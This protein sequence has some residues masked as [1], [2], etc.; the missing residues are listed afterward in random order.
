MSQI[1]DQDTVPPHPVLSAYYDRSGARSGF[2][3]SLFNRTAADYDAINGLLSLGTGAQYRSHVLRRT[4]IRPGHHLL[5]VATGTGLL[6]RAAMRLVGPE[7]RVV[8]L[9]LSERM[10]DMA[11]SRPGLLVVQGRAE[12]LP[13]PAAHFD[14]LTMGY[15]L[16][17]VASLTTAFQ[18]FHRVLRPGGRVVLLEI[19]RPRSPFAYRVARLYLGWLVPSLSRLARSGS[20]ARLLMRYFWD[21]VDTCVP[22]QV[23]L[24]AL[25]ASGFV[26]PT[27]STDFGLFHTYVASVPGAPAR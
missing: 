10:L 12:T 8:G 1:S 18:E 15:A 21:T 4:G 7:G 16:R 23:I 17:H 19:G 27:C 20:Q 6:A 2:V 11:R 22:P 25:V 9:D 14:V 5:D 26:N 24:D 13:L 3:R